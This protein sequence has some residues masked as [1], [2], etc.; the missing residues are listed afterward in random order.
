M[1][2]ST[3]LL[4]EK[5]SKSPDWKK[6]IYE[7][8]LSE[9]TFREYNL[10][11]DWRRRHDM[12]TPLFVETVNSLNNDS[13]LYDFN[14]NSMTQQNQYGNNYLRATQAQSLQFQPTQEVTSKSM[15]R[16]FNWLTQSSLESFQPSLYGA[17]F[18]ES[19]S[20]LLFSVN[21][22]VDNQTKFTN[23]ND[24]EQDILRLRRKFVRDQSNEQQSRFFARKQ[25]N[26]VNNMN[27][28]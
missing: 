10:T 11:A 20:A 27:K 23:Q 12:M 22:K 25:V 2:Y 17:S 9:C 4:L 16:P 3:N 28:D 6:F 13:S 18:T 19:Q 14:T 15:S 26:L 7:N 24:S 8:P 1:S 5:T 21:R